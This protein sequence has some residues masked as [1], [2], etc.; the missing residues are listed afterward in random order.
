MRQNECHFRTLRRCPLEPDSDPILGL[1]NTESQQALCGKTFER[2]KGLSVLQGG[3][4][5]DGPHRQRLL[6]C[7]KFVESKPFILV[8]YEGKD[9]VADDTRIQALRQ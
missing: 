6:L 9:V 3:L 2:P 1:R 7:S 5:D 8:G 4:K